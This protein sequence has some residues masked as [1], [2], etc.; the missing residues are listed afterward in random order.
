M[1]FTLQPDEQRKLNRPAPERRNYCA[2]CAKQHRSA[3]RF[4]ACRARPPPHSGQPSQGNIKYGACHSKQRPS[5]KSIAP[6]TRNSIGVQR[7]LRLPRESASKC[8]KYCACQ[9]RRLAP[10]GGQ[11]QG[12]IKYCACHAKYDKVTEC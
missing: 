7:A 10:H 4:C 9:A 2:C 12:N 5:A 1:S 11:S 6:A 3:E 8:R